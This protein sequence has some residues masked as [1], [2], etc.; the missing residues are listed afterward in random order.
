MDKQYITA[1]RLLESSVELAFS[2]IDSGFRPDLIAGIWRG[3]TP[4][5]IAV[6]EV[7]EFVGIETDHVAIRAASYTGIGERSTVSVH[8]LEYLERHHGTD[9]KLLLVDDVYDTGLSIDAIIR[10]LGSLLPEGPP[11]CRVATPWF[12]PENNRTG[13]KPDYY[14]FETNAWL[15]FPHELVGLDELE[16]IRD[17]PL[18]VTLK[19]RLLTLRKRLA[20]GDGC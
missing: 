3:G 1:E 14:L 15:V 11:E 9:Q 10:E 5:A 20:D 13:H 6:Q 17:K 8:G 12:K 7:M 18:S 2:I 19:E 4:V 16:I